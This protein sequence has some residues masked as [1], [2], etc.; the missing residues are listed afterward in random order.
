MGPIII[1]SILTATNA[2]ILAST[3]LQTAPGGGML[4]IELEADLNNATNYFEATLQLPNGDTPLENLRVP[5]SPT[6]T[7]GVLDDREKLQI[8]VPVQQGGH[9]T[10][11]LTEGGTA[12]CAY[13]V[14]FTPVR[15]R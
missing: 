9:V 2:D 7:A 10:L 15:G 8:S 3:R 13:R 4:T 14:T 5:A 11:S 1:G 12:I 6:G